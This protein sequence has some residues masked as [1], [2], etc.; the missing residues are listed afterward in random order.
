MSTAFKPR[1]L[2]HWPLKAFGTTLGM[3][4]F[5]VVYFAL[6]QHPLVPP[7]VMPATRLDAW[8]GFHPLALL[9]YVALWPYVALLPALLVDRRELTGFALGS[10]ALAV[11]G[12]AI[13][14][15]WPTTIPNPGI[16]W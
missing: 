11:A 10:L 8:I 7:V 6:L 3:G 15:V 16:D 4:A 2:R 14:L 1:V 13:F 5:F 9:P 12:L